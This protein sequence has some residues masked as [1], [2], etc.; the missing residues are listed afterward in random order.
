MSFEWRLS[1][2]VFESLPLLCGFWPSS[3]LFFSSAVHLLMP[4]LFPT[5]WK[6]VISHLVLWMTISE[7][8]LQSQQTFSRKK[9]LIFPCKQSPFLMNFICHQ[10]H[11]F[12]SFLNEK[13][14]TLF[15]PITFATCH[16]SWELLTSAHSAALARQEPPTHRSN[17]PWAL[18]ESP[19]PSAFPPHQG[20]QCHYLWHISFILMPLYSRPYNNF[21]VYI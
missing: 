10:E 1:T 8:L 17:R 13:P 12:S 15:I 4:S 3:L 6:Y 9:K 2:W 19:A 5:L 16:L 7:L 21:F 11:K 14:E 18:A 20:H